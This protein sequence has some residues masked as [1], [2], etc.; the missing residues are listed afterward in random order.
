MLGILRADHSEELRTDLGFVYLHIEFGIGEEL[1]H[2]GAHGVADT[3]F[4][5][6]AVWGSI[7]FVVQQCAAHGGVVIAQRGGDAEAIGEIPGGKFQSFTGKHFHFALVL[8]SMGGGYFLGEVGQGEGALRLYGEVI[9]ILNVFGKQVFA[10][11]EYELGSLRG[12]CH[13]YFDGLEGE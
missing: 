4:Q 6:R 2:D 13:C 1:T 5:L 9:V 8:V 11:F 12:L 7:E 3:E 10:C